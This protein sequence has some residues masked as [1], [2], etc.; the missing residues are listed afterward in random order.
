MLD[1]VETTPVD[2]TLH[3][4]HGRSPHPRTRRFITM[5]KRL[6]A[7]TLASGLLA[8]V[9]I[10]GVA[11][12]P[13]GATECPSGTWSDTVGKP[14]EV[15]PGMTGAAI[16]R[17]TDNNHFRFRVSEA[18]RDFA[19]FRG[20]IS[21]DGY[22]V[23]GQRH[24]EGGDVTLRREGGKLHFFFSNFGGVDGVDIFV[25]CASYL[26]VNVRMNGEQLGTDLIVIGGDSTH[27]AANPFTIDKVAEAA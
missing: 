5:I 19:G 24:L 9:A 3:T 12:A 2:S 16:W 10:T 4:S 18:G 25:R 11:P 26:K 22:F 17:S 7:I 1:L 15:A 23:F 13:A 21:T 8:A 20:T 14:A 6:L 27:P